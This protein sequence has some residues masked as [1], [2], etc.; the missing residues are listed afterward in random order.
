M[1]SFIYIRRKAGVH[2]MKPGSARF[3]L[4]DHPRAES[5]RTL[6]H[7]PEP[8]FAAYIPTLQGMLDDYFESWFVTTESRPEAPLG[9]GL[10]TTFALGI[11]QTWLAPPARDPR[12]DLDRD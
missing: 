4:G 8:V 12:F 10:E 5:L 1:R 6:Q 3:V 9:E 7:R 2:V 11:G